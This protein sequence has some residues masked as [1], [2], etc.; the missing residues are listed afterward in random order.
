MEKPPNFKLHRTALRAAAEF[1]VGRMKQRVI[2]FLTG[3]NMRLRTFR[4]VLLAC[5]LVTISFS[6]EGAAT[7]KNDDG[8]LYAGIASMGIGVAAG[9]AA[10]GLIL[11]ANANDDAGTGT[12]G[13]VACGIGGAALLT[14]AALF[15]VGLGKRSSST[16][17]VSVLVYPAG[18]VIDIA[19]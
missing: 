15:A 8:F 3:S 19:F 9:A 7:E 14:G 2:L 13:I 16:P 12:A 10:T 4:A 6:K 18:G 17:N 1:G 5:A 11:H